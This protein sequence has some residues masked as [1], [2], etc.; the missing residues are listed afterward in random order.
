MAQAVLS[1]DLL[2]SFLDEMQTVLQG[3]PSHPA[4]RQQVVDAV[5][6]QLQQQESLLRPKDMDSLQQLHQLALALRQPAFSQRLLATHGAGAVNRVPD[7]QAQYEASIRLAFMQA[8]AVQQQWP[9]A[10]PDAAPAPEFTA[11]LN[12]AAQAIAAPAASM[13]SLD[14]WHQLADWAERC[15]VHTLTRRC[16]EGIHAIGVVDPERAAW[17]SLDRARL[18]LQLGRSHLAEGDADAA[19][20]EGQAAYDAL[21]Q[22][23]SDQDIDHDDWLACVAELAPLM[24][25]RLHALCAQVR[26]AYPRELAP[27][28][29]RQ[30]EVK[31]ARIEAAVLQ[32][33]GDLAAALAK[34]QLGR[35]D[36]SDEDEDL[37]T[38]QVLGWLQQAGPWDTLAELVFENVW[39]VRPG[40]FE[41]A[42]GIVREQLA[43]GQHPSHL[44]PLAQAHAR[45]E[46]DFRAS[47]SGQ[48]AEQALADALAASRQIKPGNVEADLVEGYWLCKQR[49]N[50]LA[51]GKALPLLERAARE[52]PQHCN[53]DV[54]R[55]LIQARIQVQGMQEGLAL[56]PPPAQAA[57]WA[58]SLGNMMYFDDEDI[59]EQCKNK[60][61]WPQ[62]KGLELAIHYHRL[63]LQRFESFFA[64]G[65]GLF[66]DGDAH[67]YSMLCNNL[68]IELRT[69]GVE[70]VDEAIALH[71]KGLATSPF[72]EH[73]NSIMRCHKLAGRHAELI[74]AAEELWRFSEQYGFSRH[75][76]SGYIEWVLLALYYTDRD[77]E[78]SIWLPRLDGWWRALD[79]DERAEF[80]E[81]YHIALNA[82][83]R[84]MAY[85]NL[86]DALT[87]LHAVADD[88]RA[89]QSAELTR[90]LGDN[91]EVCHDLDTAMRLYREAL[92]LAQREANER[93]LGLIPE[94]I[95]KCQAAIDER[96]KA[97]EKA[98]PWWKPW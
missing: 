43:G 71:R 12:A 7:P 67:V 57:G 64:T 55:F 74:D 47:K 89:L 32:Q 6:A 3:A 72:A 11:A 13:Q 34:A 92:A 24:P 39:N 8:E 29:R 73:L 10:A 20:R 53:A 49:R 5:W 23:P 35:F 17:R 80:N 91:F 58:Y 30:C 18:H 77:A 66:R 21:S 81:S 25:E 45:L 16:A 94:A 85:V 65:Q 60:G 70:H 87:R 63:G 40:V 59:S 41:Q 15:R 42:A 51:L 62:D 78:V 76:P 4:K 82:A 93:E 56:P 46:A 50:L 68:G 44:W 75:D 88:M 19:R 97:A 95:A 31:L 54:A 96:D 86:N 52:A 33:Q 14:A 26:A 2:D 48:D 61:K 36:C 79:E 1:G 9:E 69:L 37:F 27:G 98:K 22:A 28:M 38:P 83:L 84:N 90:L